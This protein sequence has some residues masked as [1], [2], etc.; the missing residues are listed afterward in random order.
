MTKFKLLITLLLVACL[1]TPAFATTVYNWLD[2]AQAD[3][4]DADGLNWT[5]EYGDP[6]TKPD[7]QYEVKIRGPNSVV[8]LD[9]VEGNWDYTGNGTRLRI[10]KGATLNIVE[11]GEILGFGWIRVGEQTGT[12]EQIGY[13]NQTGGKIV[14]KKAKESGKLSIGDGYGLIHGSA[15]TISGG[16]LTYDFENSS[17][18]GQL[19]VGARDGEGTFVV[20]G[21]QA[22]IRM[23]NLYVAGDSSGGTAYNYGIGALHFMFGEDGVSPIVLDSTAYIDQGLY[24]IASLLITLTGAP[25][26]G[27]DIVLV[28]AATAIHGTFDFLNGGLADEGS[29][30]SLNF[31]DFNYNYTLTY[32]G[33]LDGKDLALLWID[34]IVIPEPATVFILALGGLL[35]IPRRR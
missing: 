21:N 14:L 35:S 5:D 11:G 20:I 16:T 33:G 23:K 12:P 19:I 25:P 24:S 15:Y 29:A 30:L 34:A 8:R 28:D 31:G 13:L 27:Q 18:D 7:G 3:W 2:G 32:A 10:Y 26:V 17:C 4:D 9:T 22:Q 1:T 6:I